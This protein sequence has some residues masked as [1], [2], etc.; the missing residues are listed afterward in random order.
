MKT[1]SVVSIVIRSVFWIRKTQSL[2]ALLKMRLNSLIIL[3]RNQKPILMI[4]VPILMRLAS[5][6]LSILASCAEWITTDVPYLMG[7]PINSARKARYAVAD[8]T[9]KW[10]K[11]L[12]DEPP[13]RS[14]L[15][16]AWSV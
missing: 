3:M 4:F 16:W 10:W 7:P 8:V 15:V 1:V 2:T 6:I 13:L 5:S 11:S 9:I 12:A 14:V